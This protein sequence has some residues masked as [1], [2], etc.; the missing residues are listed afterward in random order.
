MKYFLFLLFSSWAWAVPEN[1]VLE[2]WTT[3]IYPYYLQGADLNFAGQKGIQ[4][5]SKVFIHSETAPIVAIFP[6]QAEPA[7]RYSEMI[8][9]LKELGYNVAI[10]DHRGQGRSERLVSTYGLSHVDK[11]QYYVDDATHWLKQ[12]KQNYSQKI[13]LLAHSMGGAI[14]TGVVVNNPGLVEKVVLSAPMLQIETKPYPGF[15]ARGISGLMKLLG[16]K[17]AFALGQSPFNLDMPF[18][19]NTTTDS[20][21]RFQAFI[22]HYRLHPE[23][24]IGGVSNNWVAES[25]KYTKKLKKKYSSF[26]PPV[27]VFQAGQDTWVKPKRQNIFCAKARNCK[28]IHF[29]QAKHEILLHQDGTRDKALEFI[30]TF[31]RS[32]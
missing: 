31:F 11:F 21:I 30:D 2:A 26:E 20:P 32:P 17:E 14:A 25:L 16:K 28:L 12:L 22:D 4:I 3:K 1:Q 7:E 13:Y 19:E 10:I 24:V 15:V 23:I 29:N 18:A 5:V 9:D 6:G 27:F 8:W